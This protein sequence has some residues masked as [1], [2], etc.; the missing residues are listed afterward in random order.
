MQ[1]NSAGLDPL[2]GR[3]SS[4][5]DAV[6]LSPQLEAIIERFSTADVDDAVR[7]E[8]WEARIADWLYL[9]TAKTLNSKPFTASVQTLHLPRSIV[10]HVSA[11]SHIVE[12]TASHIEQSEAEAVVLN[13]TMMGDAVVY[14]ED[15][16]R[17]LHP[18]NVLVHDLDRPFLRVFARGLKELVFL[19]NREDFEMMT[20]GVECFDSGVDVFTF[21]RDVKGSSYAT[22]LAELL[23]G[24]L[25]EPDSISPAELEATAFDLLRA[26]Y[27]QTIN[28][29]VPSQSRLVLAYID[30]HLRNPA[31]SAKMITRE[32]GMS[33]RQLSRVLNAAGTTLSKAVRDR[34]LNLAR[35]VL[36]NSNTHFLTLKEVAHFCGF[37]SHAHFSRSYKEKFGVNPSD[38]RFQQ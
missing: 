33:E 29:K 16:V 2:G 13:F 23:V 36:T 17:S 18:G 37:S 7:V 38:S 21:G 3:Y 24:A 6:D 32:L 12:R 35:R 31:L 25:T 14:F 30:R 5:A 10:A 20:Q 1:A 19:V 27:T 22:S 28:L 15:G 9:I 8:M 34:R 26:M 4:G 11:E